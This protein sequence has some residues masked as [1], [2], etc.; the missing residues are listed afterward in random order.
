MRRAAARCGEWAQHFSN[1]SCLLN[2]QRISAAQQLARRRLSAAG[3]RVGFC[4]VQH[5]RTDATSIHRGAVDARSLVGRSARI[6][7]TELRE[8]NAERHSPIEPRCVSHV[9]ETAANS[10]RDAAGGW[11]A[12]LRYT[13]APQRASEVFTAYIPLS[14]NALRTTRRDAPGFVRPLSPTV[15]RRVA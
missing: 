5:A 4:S 9:R 8:R 11:A 2:Y 12:A 1:A 7:V 15:M 6:D 3:E 14:L 13:A 10:S